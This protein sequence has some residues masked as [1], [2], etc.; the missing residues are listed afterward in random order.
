MKPYR[1][2]SII[3]TPLSAY[4]GTVFL[5]I[6]GDSLLSIRIAEY[7][8]IFFIHVIFYRLLVSATENKTLSY[9]VCLLDYMLSFVG[10]IYSYNMLSVLLVLLV[11]F[12]EEKQV[13]RENE[14]LKID[15]LIGIL[16]GLTPLLKQTTGALLVFVDLIIC[17]IDICKYKKPL[18]NAVMRVLISGVPSILF[19]IYIIADGLWYW[20]YDYTIAGMG[21]FIENFFVSSKS[22]AYFSMAII[23]VSFVLSVVGIIKENDQ[24]EKRIKTNWLFITIGYSIVLLPLVEPAHMDLII[25]MYL[26][27]FFKN[28]KKIKYSK[29]EKVIVS[30]IITIIMI[31]FVFNITYNDGNLVSSSLNHFS[32]LPVEPRAQEMIINVDQYILSIEESG[33]NVYVVDDTAA[34]LMVPL[35]KYNKDFDML[36]KGNFG[37]Q[38]IE[39]MLMGK[40][41]DIFLVLSGDYE[42]LPGE[43]MYYELV[44][45]V[46]ENFE[47]VGEIDVFDA[48]QMPET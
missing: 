18:K 39:D 11:M 7:I 46:K 6:F 43:Q 28:I 26:V 14:S 8:L 30:S 45:Y 25:P 31:F 4:I 35:D 48:Y 3:I 2:F 37:T 33:K 24:K 19:L 40:N 29:I 36:N 27:N 34:F 38:T 32:P 5:M 15:L 1:D 41:G 44:D 47:K 12:F 13:S 22:L 42:I 20:F 10:Y 9:V 17:I 23:F 21:S 16:V